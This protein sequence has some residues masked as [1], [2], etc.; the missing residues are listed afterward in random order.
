MKTMVMFLFFV[1]IIIL[2]I[3]LS[4]K[5]NKWLG[6]ILPSINILFSIMAVLGLA[7]FEKET[8]IQT[9]VQCIIIFLMYNIPT[10]ILLAIYFSYRRK[11]KK[12]KE[13]EKMN[14]QDL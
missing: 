8:L 4:R 3:F 1:G 6:L 7:F 13:I 9:V 10:M 11:L 2:Q 5:K 14:I 12:N